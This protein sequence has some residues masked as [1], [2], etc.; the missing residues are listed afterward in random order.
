[1]HFPCRQSPTSTAPSGNPLPALVCKLMPT[2]EL[3]SADTPVPACA[4]A[5]SH[6]PPAEPST[7]VTATPTGG[8]GGRAVRHMS[9]DTAQ[10]LQR[11]CSASSAAKGPRPGAS[12]ARSAVG[13]HYSQVQARMETT[14]SSAPQSSSRAQAHLEPPT[15]DAAPQ[16]GDLSAPQEVQTQP[17][18]S[19]EKPRQLSVSDVA[20]ACDAPSAATV[21][22]APGM[23]GSAAVSAAGS[24]YDGVVRTPAAAG[25]VPS[26]AAA[27][28]LGVSMAQRTLDFGCPPAA[29]PAS[30]T[31]GA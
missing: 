8:G 20:S 12:T 17:A 5:P 18:G 11:A 16:P 7:P 22:A 25:A 19:P 31:A 21:N 14:A 15:P 3:K 24:S 6:A 4:H 9:P 1:M 27:A 2:P 28:A 23:V 10:L 29:P 26:A 13:E 30:A